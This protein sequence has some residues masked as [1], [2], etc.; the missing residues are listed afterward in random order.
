[1]EPRA[2][3]SD[4]HGNLEAFIAVLKDLHIL[5]GERRSQGK[6]QITKLDL[7]G[8][9]VNYGPNSGEVLDIVRALTLPESKRTP[10]VVKKEYADLIKGFSAGVVLPGNHDIT[11]KHRKDGE[12]T[13]AGMHEGPY[14]ALVTNTTELFKSNP[15]KYLSPATREGILLRKQIDIPPSLDE[16]LDELLGIVVDRFGRNV[17]DISGWGQETRKEAVRAFMREEAPKLKTELGVL[18]DRKRPEMPQGDPVLTEELRTYEKAKARADFLDLLAKKPSPGVIKENNTYCFHSSWLHTKMWEYVFD[19]HQLSIYQSVEG[20]EPS[21]T[22]AKSALNLAKKIGGSEPLIVAHGHSHIP[23][24]YKASEDGANIIVI[25]T[26]TVGMPRAKVCPIMNYQKGELETENNCH[27]KASYAIMDDEGPKIRFVQYD[28]WKET[29]QKMK[30][31]YKWDT[32][33]TDERKQMKFMK[34]W[35]KEI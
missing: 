11:M 24:I 23:G 2:L 34:T 30:T 1:M 22:K 4:I 25:D 18:F 27:T 29:Y 33:D 28:G 31:L 21:H 13:K 20:K 7:L 14:N 16:T 26:G 17:P 5:N 9:Y 8:D 10:D 35:A 15:K 32:L 19:P 12:N 3:L 6:E